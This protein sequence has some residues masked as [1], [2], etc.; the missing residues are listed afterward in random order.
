MKLTIA[1]CQF[2]ISVD[3]KKNYDYIVKQVKEAKRKN[4]HVVHFP[5][6]CLSGYAGTDFASYD[7]YDWDTLLHYAKKVLD[8][9]KEQGVWIVLGST[10]KLSNG[11]KPHS[12]LYIINNKGKIIDWYD[13]RFCSGAAQ[14]N[15]G[16][17]VYYTP[18]NHFVVFEI[19]GIKCGTLVCHEYRYPELYREYEKREVQLIFHSYHTGNINKQRYKEMQ[20]YVGGELWNF[21][22][23]STLPEIT[24]PA[25]MHMAAA[26]NYMWISCPT[27]CAKQSCW[28]SF[29]VRSDG[30]ITGKPKKNITGVLISEID[31]ETKYYDSTIAWRKRAM[32]GIFHSGMIVEDERSDTRTKL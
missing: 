23:G 18:G 26:N 32:E 2:P 13:K 1:T 10:H 27:S 7:D 11:N 21:N 14:S 5:E 12:S 29:F 9:A 15:T 6:T 20:D 24:M 22:N 3:I 25:A 8:L 28:S 17:L 30:V 31:T 16:D 4:A 19:N